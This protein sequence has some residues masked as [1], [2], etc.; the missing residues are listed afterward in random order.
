MRNAKFIVGLFSILL[1]ASMLYQFTGARADNDKLLAL[2]E[3][4]VAV[5]SQNRDNIAA[6]KETLDLIKDCVQVGGD[7]YTEN[8]ARTG[9][10]VAGLNLASA[11]A[12]ICGEEVD[13]EDAILACIDKNIAQYVKAQKQQDAEQ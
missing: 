10:L 1:V 13:G 4:L 7:C 8:S 9:E 5:Q 11:Y 12:V 3:Q 2:G 6:A